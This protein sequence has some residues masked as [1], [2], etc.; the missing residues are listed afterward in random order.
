MASRIQLL[1]HAVANKIAAGEVVERPAS[2]LKEL[3]ENSLDAGATQIDVEVVAGGRKLLS[4]ADNGHGMDRDDALM[5]VERHATSKVRDVHDIE[6]IQTMGFRG[7]ALAAISS[8]S[9]FTLKT[10]PQGEVEGTEVA[11]NGGRIQDVREAGCAPGTLIE[12]R[13]LFY[14]VPARKKFLRTEQTEL[15]HVRDQFITQALAHPDVGMSLK[16]DGRMSYLLA[17]GGVLL[18]RLRDIFGKGYENNLVAVDAKTDEVHITGHISLPG[19]SRADRHEQYIFVNGRPASA[20]VIAHAIREGYRTLMTSDRHPL[21]FL[22]LEMGPDL[23]DVNVHPTKKEVRFR[24]PR[25]VRDAVIETIQGALKRDEA[26]GVPLPQADEEPHF[27]LSAP[28]PEPEQMTI[29]DLPPTRSFKYPAIPLV[30]PSEPVEAEGEAADSTEVLSDPAEMDAAVPADAPWSYC[31]VLGQ[32]GDLYVFLETDDGYV[33]MDPHAAH[34]RVLFDRFMTAFLKK[35]VASQA[36]LLPETVD[37]LPADARRV[38]DNLALFEQMG[39]GVSDFGG[40]TFVVDALPSYFSHANASRILTD[41]A[42]TLDKSGAK[43]GHET[44]RENAVATAAC[45][46]A[47]KARDRLTSEE[48]EQLVVDLAQTRMPYTCPHGRPTLIFT[49]YRELNRKFGR[50]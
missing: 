3:L 20:P 40:D 25:Q 18:D 39:F 47:V 50:E 27:E 29:I 1:S 10:C 24:H 15:S 22:N 13:N 38:R 8:V 23:V 12:V 14:N 34:E 11:V 28:A 44:W 35:E 48:L 19:A 46:A 43:G 37:L 30:A 33:I 17:G 16:V 36:L 45:R 2:V 21:L 6:N 32:I 31:R 49:S 26:G 41:V 9:R 42:G 5:S 4:I 7:E